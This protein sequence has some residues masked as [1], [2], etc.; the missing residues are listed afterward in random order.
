MFHQGASLILQAVVEVVEGEVLVPELVE[1]SCAN[2]D[3]S[4]QKFCRAHS[5]E[6]DVAVGSSP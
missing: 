6:P 2:R 1:E 3:D 4:S 5:D